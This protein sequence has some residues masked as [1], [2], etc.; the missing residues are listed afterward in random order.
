[1]TD[2]LIERLSADLKPISAKAVEKRLALAAGLGLAAAAACAYVLLHRWLG[3][4]FGG[5]EGH[6]MF[7]IKL[8]YTLALGV[9]G[10]AAAPALARPD[11]RIGW[12]FIGAGL[13]VLL[14]LGGGA[15]AWSATNWNMVTL[16]GETAM[17]CPW[18]IAL[19]GMPILVSLLVALRSM[20]PRSPAR[21]GLAA[22]LAAGGLGAMVYAFYCG[23]TG[24]TFMAVWYT[25]GM[26][27]TA[28]AG[29]VLGRLLLRW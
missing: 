29:L 27:L 23:E 19:T 6:P 16:M 14:A 20:A 11:G 3:R 9:A 17:V 2:D 13:V 18:L 12:P 28:V 4:P 26:A 7:W 24:L 8:V 22:G 10:A 21:A 15:L 25:A 5:A 1:M